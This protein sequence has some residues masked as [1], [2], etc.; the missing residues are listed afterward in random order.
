MVQKEHIVVKKQRKIGEFQW[1]TLLLALISCANSWSQKPMVALTA[2]T[3]KVAP[4]DNITLTVTS[5]VEGSVKIDFPKELDVDYAIVNGME[6]KMDPSGKIKTYYYMQQ[7]GQFSKEG[8]Y[9]FSAHI[10]YKNKVYNSN[11][12]TIKVDEAV[13]DEAPTIRSGDPVFGYIEAKKL[14][15]YEG[16][17]VLL[18]AKI[19]S[20][21][22]IIDL[23][24]YAPFKADKKVETHEFNNGRQYV[25][26]TKLNGKPA[27]S[28]EYGKQLYI[29]VT[30]G[31]CK[32][33]PFEMAIRCETP[34]FDRVIRFKSSPLT[35]T[36]KPLPGNA[37]NCFIGAVGAFDLN[38]SI[39]DV[40]KLKSGEVFTISLTVSGVGNLHNIN[41]PNLILPKGCLLYGDPEREEN[42]QFT[43]GGVTGNITF[44][45]N[46]QVAQ[47]GDFHFEAPA[48]AFF[49]PDKEKYVT[50]KGQPFSLSIG[51]TG[52]QNSIVM[53]NNSSNTTTKEFITANEHKTSAKQSGNTPMILGI[54]IPT[55][56]LSS[57]LLLLFVNK[58]RKQRADNLTEE[59][60]TETFICDPQVEETTMDYWYEVNQHASDP[61]HV[62]IFLPKAI[63]QLVQQRYKLKEECS[64]DILFARLNEENEDF[65]TVVREI[66]DTCDH[67]RYGFGVQEFPSHELIQTVRE[68]F[69]L[70]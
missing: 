2:D 32:I 52:K 34:L 66:I 42:I 3:K 31:K 33:K 54:T 70:P 23:E 49:D 55:L 17:P 37:P 11:K 18:N 35:L 21:L 22:Q 24:G 36:V 6:Q 38:Q 64:R 13:A 47:S 68:M 65:S 39:S 63:A 40:S 20:R 51:A 12:I 60:T 14:T 27:L 4:G 26:E 1:M 62:A 50:V 53:K 45:Y 28:F 56:F 58:K 43:E 67:Y 69:Q 41:A 25:E 9:T 48:I 16:E 5:N 10:T 59:P 19:I 30:T 61:N 57:I 44:R 15:V 46:V 7:S 29:P 8:S